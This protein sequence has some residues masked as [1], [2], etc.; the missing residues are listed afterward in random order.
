LRIHLSSSWRLLTRLGDLPEGFPDQGPS[1][2][3]ELFP[4]GDMNQQSQQKEPGLV[5]TEDLSPLTAAPKRRPPFSFRTKTLFFP[6]CPYNRISSKS[7]FRPS[8]GSSPCITCLFADIFQQQEQPGRCILLPL[9]SRHV[10]SHS[11]VLPARAQKQECR[12][13]T[14]EP[15]SSGRAPRPSPSQCPHSQVCSPSTHRCPATSSPG[16]CS[17]GSTFKRMEE[18]FCGTLEGTE[19]PLCGLDNTTSSPSY[20]LSRER[21]T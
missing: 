14:P 12:G 8:N 21:D 2:M 17:A 9:Q 5:T 1:R 20:L 19:R 7:H 10:S 18:F 6:Q 15:Q 3:T 16:L 11:P 4:Q 13:C